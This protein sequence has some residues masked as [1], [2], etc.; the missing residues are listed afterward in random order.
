[1]DAA[2]DGQ[3]APILSPAPIPPTSDC[4]TRALDGPKRHHYLLL[5]FL[6]HECG[7]FTFGDK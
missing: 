5:Y 1:M 7:H 4:M 6:R 3:T 2:I